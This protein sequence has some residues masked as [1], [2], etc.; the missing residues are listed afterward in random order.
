VR[1]EVEP[2]WR[3]ATADLQTG[4]LTLQGG[5]FYAA[6]WF[7]QQAAEKALKALHFE[8]RGRLPRRTH[9]LPF[10]GLQLTVPHSVQMDLDA[11]MAAF[12]VARYPD[13]LGVA[14]VDTIG[15]DDATEHLDAARR[16][17]AWVASEL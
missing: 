1:P 2:W 14:P 9:D 4:E 7:A 5:Q 10:L 15:V 3:Q 6:S 12:D 16:I 13:T 11:L 8:R 17:L